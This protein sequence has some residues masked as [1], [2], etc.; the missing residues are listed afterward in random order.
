MRWVTRWQQA[1]AKRRNLRSLILPWR[2]TSMGTGSA[3]ASHS[4]SVIAVSFLAEDQVHGP[5]ALGMPTGLGEV[6]G[7]FRF[8]RVQERVVER[9]SAVLAAVECLGELADR[10]GPV[11]RWRRLAERV[12]DDLA[13]H[14]RLL[15]AF[16]CLHRA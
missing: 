7:K 1:Q 5:A 16:A 13:Q 2:W 9:E 15:V 10:I 11:V 6:L 8:S 12:A 14:Q 4:A 3:Q